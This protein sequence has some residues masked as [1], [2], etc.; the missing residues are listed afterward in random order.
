MTLYEK[1]WLGV[2]F[3]GQGLFSA[4]FLIQW[5]MSEKQRKSVIPLEFWYFS[6]AGGVTL[7]AYALHKRDPVFI[8]GQSFGLFIYLRNLFFIR[9]SQ[10]ATPSC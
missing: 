2:G 4:R 7:L 1:I 9:K 5:L 10:T 3:L 6:L 8:M